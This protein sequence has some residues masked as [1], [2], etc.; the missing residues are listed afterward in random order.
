MGEKKL[1]HANKNRIPFGKRFQRL[2]G[3]IIVISGVGALIYIG[4]SMEG[5]HFID[6]KKQQKEIRHL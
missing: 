3:W 1:K 2:M 4:L 5:G 6:N